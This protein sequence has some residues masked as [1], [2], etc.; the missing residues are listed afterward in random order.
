M[1]MMT[2]LALKSLPLLGL[3]HLLVRLRAPLV[4]PGGAV[5]SMR[6][7]ALGLLLVFDLIV[8]QLGR[9]LRVSCDERR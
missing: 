3:P 5:I 9:A 1:L 6:H 8:A 4:L 7:V 2:P